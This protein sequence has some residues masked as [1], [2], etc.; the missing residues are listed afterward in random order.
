MPTTVEHDSSLSYTDIKGYKFH[1]FQQGNEKNPV[2]IVVHGGP[3]GD[4]HY[5]KSLSPLSDNY[6]V[7]FYDQRGTG[8]S[9][10]VDKNQLTIEQSLDD[11][12]LIVDHFAGDRDVI[13]IGHS[14]GGMLVTGYLSKYPNKVSHAVVVEPGM[15]YPDAAEAFIKKMK[16]SQSFLDALVL[17]GYTTVYPFVHKVDG[18][19]GFDYVMTKLLNRSK[20]GAPYQC[21]NESMPPDAFKRAGYDAF[22]NMLRPVMKN[23]ELFDYDLTEGITNFGGKLML[24]SSE[25]SYFGYEFQETFHLP[26]M[27]TQ[28]QHIQAKNMGHNMLTLNPEWSLATIRGFL[29]Q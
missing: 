4:H 19:E 29:Q 21:K 6:H 22:D 5:L 23:P 15:L 2:V 11:L 12:S 13:L 18:H 26:K 16:S 10:R 20:P 27:P 8:L 1:T 17:V 14:W 7:V 3:G 24:I 25:C 9:P 28:T